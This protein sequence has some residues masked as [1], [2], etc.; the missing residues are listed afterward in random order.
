MRI[1]LRGELD[2]ASADRVAEQIG[3]ALDGTA[4]G[5]LVVDVAGLTFCDSTGV[6]VLISA[7]DTAR[8]RG[9]D[10]RVARPRGIVR[11]AMIATGTFEVLT[12]RQVP[13]RP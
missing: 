10:L 7:Q 12:G 9:I 13:A 11:R 1:A 5:Q 2:L 3:A 6:D 4:D 8:D